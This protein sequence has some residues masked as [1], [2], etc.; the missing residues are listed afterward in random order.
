MAGSQISTAETVVDTLK[1]FQA[2][3]LTNFDTSAATAIAAGSITEIDGTIFS[4]TSDET[5]TGWSSIATGETAYIYITDDGEPRYTSTEPLWNDQAQGWYRW[6]GFFN[7]SRVIASVTKTSAT[8]YDD[9]KL[10]IM[11]QAPYPIGINEQN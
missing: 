1:G 4:F 5:P 9:K 11:K 10:M 3:S 6:S 2:I 7:S 8:Q